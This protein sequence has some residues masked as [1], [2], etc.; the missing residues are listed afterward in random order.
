[1]GDHRSLRDGVA[2]R[3]R[4]VRHGARCGGGHLH[5]GFVRLQGDQGVIHRH[6]VSR[7]DVHLDHRDVGEVADVGDGDLHP[8]VHPGRRAVSGR[9]LA[10]GVR[11]LAHPFLRRDRGRSLGVD[12]HDDAAL[13]HGVADRD[14]QLGDRAGHG[15]RHVEGGLVRLER[16]QRVLDG[17]DVA[18]GDVH[19]DHRYVGEVADVGDLDL[20][21]SHGQRSPIRG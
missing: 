15:R 16:E 18:W 1:M 7:R 8:V 6:G 9:L 21:R 13:G 12:Q 10:I 3:D 14:A 17:N 2:D 11:A 4:Y 19:L 20:L 5:G